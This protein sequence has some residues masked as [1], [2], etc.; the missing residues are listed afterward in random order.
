M[1]KNKCRVCERTLA[2]FKAGPPGLRKRA[3]DLKKT[4]KGQIRPTHVTVY[5][6]EDTG[7]EAWAE[8]EEK[9]GELFENER[10]VKK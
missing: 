5:R 4:A 7:K 2:I 1:L 8:T 10:K 3:D 9:S 6:L